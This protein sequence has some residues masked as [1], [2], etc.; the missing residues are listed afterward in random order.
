[1]HIQRDV[2]GNWRR[3]FDLHSYPSEGKVKQLNVRRLHLLS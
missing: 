2:L 3:R 1:M